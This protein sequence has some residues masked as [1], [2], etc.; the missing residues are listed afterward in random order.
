MLGMAP[1]PRCDLWFLVLLCSVIPQG[2]ALGL[3]LPCPTCF[4]GSWVAVWAL[5]RFRGLPVGDQVGCRHPL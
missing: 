1:V 2:Q 3:H 5:G 4:W